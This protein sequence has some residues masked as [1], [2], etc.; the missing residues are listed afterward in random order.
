VVRSGQDVW[1]YGFSM[2]SIGEFVAD[3]QSCSRAQRRR[4]R[5]RKISATM[6]CRESRSVRAGLEVR[7]TP[8]LDVVR[9]MQE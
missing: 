8:R 7:D 5:G 2:I 3:G 4:I 9:E 1:V 6:D